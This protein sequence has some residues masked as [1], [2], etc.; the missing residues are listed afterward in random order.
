MVK[1]YFEFNGFGGVMLPAVIW[2][3]EHTKA[4]LQIAHGMTEH[5]GRYEEFAAEMVAH[6]IAV[7]GFDLR[8]HGRNPGSPEVAS[9]GEKGWHASQIGRAHV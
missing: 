9:F 3:P 2:K 5:M 6:G 8:G 1:D 4:V 7:A